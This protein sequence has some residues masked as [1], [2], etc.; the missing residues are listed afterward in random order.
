MYRHWEFIGHSYTLYITLHITLYRVITIITLHYT[1]FPH[2][3]VTQQLCQA[4]LV[5][6][7][8]HEKVL[9]FGL[10]LVQDSRPIVD[11]KMDAVSAR[12]HT[13]RHSTSQRHGGIKCNSVSSR[14]TVR[15]KIKRME[16]SYM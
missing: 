12:E 13:Q 3:S 8:I 16:L 4:G 10:I 9:I 7:M 14:V 2:Y 5:K 6:S 11:L 1:N 15:H